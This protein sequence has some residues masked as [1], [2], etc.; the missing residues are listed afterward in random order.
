MGDVA[1]ADVS[2]TLTVSVSDDS[3][4]SSSA[5]ESGAERIGALGT[6][7]FHALTL[8]PGPCPSVYVGGD[9]T[10]EVYVGG[11]SLCSES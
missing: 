2:T 3:V 11:L 6:L 5:S 10:L 8:S 1:A 4:S 9:V 7:V